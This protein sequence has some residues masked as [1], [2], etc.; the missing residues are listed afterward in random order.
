[1]NFEF[2]T[3]PKNIDCDYFYIEF[4]QTYISIAFMH[5]PLNPWNVTFTNISRLVSLFEYL[6]NMCFDYV[7]AYSLENEI[8]I[9]FPHIKSMN[10]KYL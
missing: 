8:L 3:V 4:Q 10:F 5:I 1:M 2:L 6:K 9:A 7:L